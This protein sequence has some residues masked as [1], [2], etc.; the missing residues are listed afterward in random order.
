MTSC[1]VLHD[2]ILSTSSLIS[3]DS[4]RQILHRLASRQILRSEFLTTLS[5]PFNGSEADRTFSLNG[6]SFMLPDTLQLLFKNETFGSNKVYSRFTVFKRNPF[7]WGR[8][9][10]K[11]R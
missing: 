1:D 9:Y 2:D 11:V 6:T 3:F 4:I 7:R 8:E 10:A 5:A